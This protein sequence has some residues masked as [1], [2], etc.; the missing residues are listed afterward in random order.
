M[1]KCL[2]L[3]SL[4]LILLAACGAQPRP[5][6]TATP[7]PIN[8]PAPTPAPSP[9]GVGAGFRFSTYGPGYDPGPEY[10]ASVGER[11]AAK[12]SAAKPRA[13]W[14]V[15]NYAGA[16]PLLTFPGSHQNLNIHFSLKDKNEEALTLFDQRGVQ[17]WLQVEPGDVPVEELIDVI[18]DRYQHHASVIGIGVDVEWFHSDGTPEGR[19]VTDAE[20]ASWVHAARA[21]QPHYRVFLK[22]WEAEKMP[23]TYRDGLVFIDDSQQFENLDQMVDEFAAW[24]R[25]FAPAPVGFQYGYPDDK[26]WWGELADPAGEIGRALLGR[27]PNTEGLYWVDFT[28][29]ETFPPAD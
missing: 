2:I 3:F 10:W 26:K 19:A 4:L 21:H 15:G 8:T 23:P 11:M 25:T 29:L 12:F 24:A 13:I 16:G 1:L 7:E 22:H 14:I 27:V 20:A 5:T 6:L 9:M 17:V 18:L 28:V